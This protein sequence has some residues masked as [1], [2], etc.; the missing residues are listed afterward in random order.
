MKKDP[1][2]NLLL[3]EDNKLRSF[4]AHFQGSV[5]L[6]V[7]FQKVLCR[8]NQVNLKR[9]KCQ[10][11]VVTDRSFI[12]HLP[13]KQCYADCVSTHYTHTHTHKIV[14]PGMSTGAGPHGQNVSLP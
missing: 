6:L 13:A 3:S 14:A 11:E 7:Y 10:S 5:A 1:E 4:S 2:M 9:P 12:V 8:T